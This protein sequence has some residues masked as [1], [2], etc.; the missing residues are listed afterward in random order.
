MMDLQIGKPEEVNMCPRRID[1]IKERARSWVDGEMHSALVVM[2]A[3]QGKIVLQEAFGRMSVEPDA[4]PIQLDTI[5]PIVSQTKMIT[6]TAIMMLVEE[7]RLG[8]HR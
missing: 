5:F 2:V 4:A 3:R 7:A 8:P 1:L 6:A